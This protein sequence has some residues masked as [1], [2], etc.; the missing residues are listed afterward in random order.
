MSRKK[1]NALVAVAIAVMLTAGAVAAYAATS[2]PANSSPEQAASVAPGPERELRGYGLSA[3]SATALFTLAS[4]ETVGL[5][6][7]SAAKCLVRSLGTRYTGETCATGAQITEGH[8]VS[9]TDECSRSGDDLMEIT[10]LAPDG[11]ASVALLS[12]D[13]TS[14]QSSVI[15]GAFRFDGKNPAAGQP[16]PTGLRWIAADGSSLGTAGLPV[17]GD[18]FC[19]PTS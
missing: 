9:I 15:D 2:T 8:G 5:V 11:T 4:G 10:G 6:Q 17:Q 19:L 3:A 7:S 16:Y 1:Q 18:S 12:S 13:G 14:R